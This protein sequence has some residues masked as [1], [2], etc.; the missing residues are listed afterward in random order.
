[1][2]QVWQRGRR[3]RRRGRHFWQRFDDRR[4]DRRRLVR[5]SSKPDRVVGL[6]NQRERLERVSNQRRRPRADEADH[7]ATKA[8]QTRFRPRRDDERQ[9]L[10]LEEQ[11]G[12]QACAP[13][14]PLLR[15]ALQPQ[16]ARSLAPEAEQRAL[17]S[18]CHD[19]L[20]SDEVWRVGQG[21]RQQV[22][23][24]ERADVGLDRGL[25]STDGL[26]H[27]GNLPLL[28]PLLGAFDCQT[29][30]T[31]TPVTPTERTCLAENRYPLVP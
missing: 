19:H 30:V 28:Q 25:Q 5:I 27:P 9:E 23:A 14:R 26:Q 24:P 3:R 29:Y 1:M 21:C 13:P 31:V 6:P 20:G 7:S 22:W 16:G 18:R 8:E 12:A 15:V 4:W 10:R 11:Q 2:Q 17:R